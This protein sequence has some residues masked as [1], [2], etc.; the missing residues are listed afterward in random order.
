MYTQ[1]NVEFQCIQRNDAKNDGKI[2]F[3]NYKFYFI[4][5]LL[6]YYYSNLIILF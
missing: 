1:Y 3:T 4:L 5:S 6:F 2:E